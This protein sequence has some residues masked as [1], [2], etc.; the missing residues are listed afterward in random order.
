MQSNTVGKI[1]D[2][3]KLHSSGTVFEGLHESKSS[4]EILASVPLDLEVFLVMR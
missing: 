1:I 2:K 4:M 3:Q